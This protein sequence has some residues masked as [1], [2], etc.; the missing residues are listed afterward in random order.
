MTF[1]PK[2]VFLNELGG[3]VGQ[4]FHVKLSQPFQVKTGWKTERKPDCILPGFSGGSSGFSQLLRDVR[5]KVLGCSSSPESMCRRAG[6]GGQG[7]ASFILVG[8]E[9]SQVWKQAQVTAVHAAK[10]M[11]AFHEQ[12]WQDLEGGGTLCLQE[13]KRTGLQ[14]NGRLPSST[15]K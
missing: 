4:C 10:E 15:P 12:M 11:Q 14:R 9:E 8:S 7:P 3:R 13:G 6:Q 1:I 2:E 5:L